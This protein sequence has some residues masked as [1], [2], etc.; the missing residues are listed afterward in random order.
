MSSLSVLKL[1]LIVCIHI[2]LTYPSF[3]QHVWN[4]DVVLILFCSS[5]MEQT[6]RTHM[7]KNGITQDFRVHA[8]K[9]SM[10]IILPHKTGYMHTDTVRKPEHMKTKQNKKIKLLFKLW[11]NYCSNCEAVT[12]VQALVL[13]ISIFHKIPLSHTLTWHNFSFAS[14]SKHI[15]TYSQTDVLFNSQNICFRHK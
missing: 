3:W 2:C 15:C 12:A 13:N 6:M 10:N 7:C 9:P 11:E 8:Y 4:W 1:K 5:V 14:I